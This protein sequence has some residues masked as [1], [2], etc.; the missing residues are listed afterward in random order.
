MHS[1][2]PLCSTTPLDCQ[3]PANETHEK[4]TDLIWIHIQT[5]APKNSYLCVCIEIHKVVKILAQLT[6]TWTI[7]M[8]VKVILVILMV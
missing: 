3:C 4:N 7:R 1:Y 8:Q 2:I 5:D 6:F